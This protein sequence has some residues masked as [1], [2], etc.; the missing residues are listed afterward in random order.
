MNAIKM[1]GA[2]PPYLG[3][4]QVI[5]QLMVYF[6]ENPNLPSGNLT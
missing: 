3:I 2:V 6:M 1:A 5:S 4:A